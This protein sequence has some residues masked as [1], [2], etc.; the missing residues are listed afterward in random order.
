M[1]LATLW[2][3]LSQ[4]K[5]S[6]TGMRPFSGTLRTLQNLFSNL[7]ENWSILAGARYKG[8]DLRFWKTE[9]NLWCCSAPSSSF[10][11]VLGQESVQTGKTWN[12]RLFWGW[13][14]GVSADGPQGEPIAGPGAEAQPAGRAD[15]DHLGICQGLLGQRGQD[16]DCCSTFKQI[17]SR[18]FFLPVNWIS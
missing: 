10:P 12:L 13:L 1:W 3:P 4:H 8:P 6:S 16:K 18:Y 9:Q 7:F 2:W 14:P 11:K 5:N 17:W 15:Q